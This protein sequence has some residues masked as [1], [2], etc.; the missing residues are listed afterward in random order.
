M[1]HARP[2]LLK[3]CAAAV[4]S[5]G[6]AATAQA[7]VPA[8]VGN[9]PQLPPPGVGL[10]LEQVL[11][12]A[13]SRSEA[14]AIARAAIRRAE[15][16]TVQARS[17][18]FPQLSF[19]GSYDRALASEFSNLFNSNSFAG[20][21]NGG[22]SGNGGNDGDGNTDNPIEDLPFGR[23]NTW[24]AS[25]TF[26]QNVYTG[27]RVGAQRRIASI[28]TEAAGYGL[29]TTR[30]QALL[31]ITQAYY[32]GLLADRLVAIAQATLDQAGATLRQTQAGFTAGTQPEFEVLRAR[33]SRDN[34]QPVLIRQRANREIALLR[35]KQLL[36]LPASY[37]LRLADTLESDTLPPPP[38]FATRVA[39]VEA[40]MGQALAQPVPAEAALLPS[41]LPL[42][43]RVAVAEAQSTL[44]LREATLSLTEAQKYPSVAINSS[45]SRV[46]YPAGVVP[47]FDRTNWTLGASVQ[48]PLLTGGRQR[49]DEAVARADVESARLQVQ[50]T[51]ELAALDTRSAYAE[52]LAARAAYDAT[53]GTVQQATRAY[54]IASVRVQAGVSTQLE[55]SDSRLQ[56]QQAHANRAVAA[57]DLQVARAHVA[58]LPELPVGG[59]TVTPR[60]SPSAVP[61]QQA[62]TTPAQPQGGTQQLFNAGAG[63]QQFTTTG[64]R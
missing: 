42:P 49:G 32:D 5:A 36:E 41:T 37:D 46:G 10:S 27:G 13:E 38:V 51:Q 17:G 7:Q 58:L 24:R 2:S 16:A 47:L 4:L 30:A 60:S 31:D 61:Q 34:Q 53:A 25:L 55:L 20:G 28:G 59:R 33:V 57:R 26:S 15:G 1:S 43:D 22:T 8:A 23:S 12:V 40:Q 9:A 29:T 54:D 45:Y 48:V 56:L 50:Q 39:A 6:L 14:I 11:D 62:P 64:T 35:L 52:L 63:A 18:L 3:V 21:D 19:T 44:R